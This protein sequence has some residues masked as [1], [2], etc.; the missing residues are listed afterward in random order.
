MRRVAVALTC[1]ASLA[2][3][4]CAVP[5][6]RDDLR[7]TKVAARDTEVTAVFERYR[8]VR[9]TAISLLDPKPLS[10]VETGPVLAI[11][12]GSFEVAQRLAQ[13][14]DQDTSSV[15][16]TDVR[17]PAFGSYPLWFYAVVRDE[18]RGVNR[19][20]VFER[21]SAVEPWLL[22]ATPETVTDTELP[23]LRDGPAG[24]VLTVEP[25][26]ARGMAMSAR[27]AAA[28]Y[29]KALAD[30][31][32]PETKQVED[33][34]FIRQMRATAQKNGSLD[35]VEFSQTWGAED[36]QY[37]LRTADGGALAFVT[38]LR[39]D[40]YTVDDG[41]TI[42]WPQNSPQQA[43]LSSGISSS[44]KLRYYHQVLLHLPGGKGK[45]RAIGQYGGVVGAD[46]G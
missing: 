3:A 12:S 46:G 39:A 17:T 40:T 33:D 36:V 25:D 14:E 1:V 19:V 24:T 44:G 9:N 23:E 2:L 21:S 16:V 20:Q 41:L 30:P 29:A 38:L 8:A 28:T 7:V 15:E 26:D 32:A 10:T 5:N 22:V 31:D 34:S 18:T 11:D 42:T 13:K 37:V 4:A 35:K 45:P 27:D 6:E 43:F